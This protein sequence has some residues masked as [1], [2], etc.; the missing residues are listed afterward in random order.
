MKRANFPLSPESVDKI[1]KNLA[2]GTSIRNKDKQILKNYVAN[3]EGGRGNSKYTP[4]VVDRIAKIRKNLDSRNLWKKSDKVSVPS[5]DAQSIT[6]DKKAPEA[7]RTMVYYNVQLFWKDKE[8]REIYGQQP[9]IQV[10]GKEYN[11]TSMY[12]KR[13]LSGEVPEAKTSEEV[14]EKALQALFED[15]AQTETPISS[16]ELLG[17]RDWN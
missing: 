2:S 13:P 4:K 14:Y 10:E 16:I 1:L 6:I 3:S 9:L 12:M 11:I 8:G 17:R 15:F 5:V 7:R